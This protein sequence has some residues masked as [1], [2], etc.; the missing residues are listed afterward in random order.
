[1]ATFRLELFCSSCTGITK[2]S[3]LTTGHLTPPC[4]ISDYHSVVPVLSRARY[5]LP[6]ETHQERRGILYF[7]VFSFSPRRFICTTQTGSKGSTEVQDFF[8]IKRELMP[9]FWHL[10][11]HGCAHIRVHTN[12]H[13]HRR[14]VHSNRVRKSLLN[15]DKQIRRGPRKKSFKYCQVHSSHPSAPPGYPTEHTETLTDRCLNF[16]SWRLTV[17]QK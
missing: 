4:L 8:L 2:A 10:C 17:V 9:G 14:T 6:A 11:M 7:L 3:K 12:A 16:Q 1:M 5:T 13:T 15:C